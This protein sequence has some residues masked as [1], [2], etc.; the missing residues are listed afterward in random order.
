METLNKLPQYILDWTTIV[1][2]MRNVNTYKLA[3]GRAILECVYQKS[4]LE[5]NKDL[6]IQ[7]TDLAKCV[8]K[9]YWNQGFFFNIKQGSTKPIICTYV[10]QLIDSYTIKNG[11]YPKWWYEA[12]GFFSQ[13]ILGEYYKKIS[14]ALIDNPIP[15]FL[16]VDKGTIPVYSYNKKEIIITYENA[17]LIKEYNTILL[18]VLNF[19]WAK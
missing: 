11:S 16:Y 18:D 1:K 8:L 4:D 19:K 15:R 14:R 7:I 10:E 17:I 2:S 3:L 6:I 13:K 12:C 9:Y 5:E